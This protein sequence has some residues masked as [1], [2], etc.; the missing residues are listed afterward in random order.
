MTKYWTWIE[1]IIQ[2]NGGCFVS[3]TKPTYA[4]LIVAQAVPAIQSGMW[5]HINKDFFND[6]P[7]VLATMKGIDENEQV[8]AYYDSKKDG[9]GNA[10]L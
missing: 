5:D 1:G 3:G 7:G 9:A 8:K 2:E 6:Y 10:E 4:D